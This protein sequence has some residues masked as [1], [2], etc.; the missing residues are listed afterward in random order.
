[1]RLRRIQ[2][3]NVSVSLR[4][5]QAPSLTS[6][7]SH[8]VSRIDPRTNEVI[9]AI[10]LPADLSPFGVAARDD[11]VWVSIHPFRSR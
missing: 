5:V 7:D 10:G 9:A 6:R 11:G 1:M 8:D 2:T 4:P 3:G